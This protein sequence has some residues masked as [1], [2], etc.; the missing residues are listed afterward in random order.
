MVDRYG[1]TNKKAV[2]FTPQTKVRGFSL[3]LPNEVLQ[4]LQLPD[5]GYRTR[6]HTS[7]RKQAREG[8]PYVGLLLHKSR[9]FASAKADAY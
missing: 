6:K 7:K 9:A 4:E 1:T 8:S 3:T 5:K 2:R